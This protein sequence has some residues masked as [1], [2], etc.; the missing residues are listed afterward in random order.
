MRLYG[1]KN[2]RRLVDK[3]T[4]KK[5][6][7]R[8]AILWTIEEEVC[9]VKIQGSN[10]LVVAHFPRNQREAPLWLRKG[11]AVRIVHKDGIRG[12]IEIVGEGRSIPAPVAG[13][14]FPSIGG[15]SD[16]ILSGLVVTSTVPAS[17]NVEISA[18]SYRIGGV[19]YYME[20]V[21]GGYIVMD[22]PAPMIM[23]D[24]P[25]V[26]NGQV[27]Y[28]LGA[29][30]GAGFFRYDIIVIGTD[31]DLDLIVG[32]EVASDPVMPS[33]PS[34]HILVNFILRIGGDTDV[35]MRRIGFLY[36]ASYP[37]FLDMPEGLELSWS[38]IIDNPTI[39]FTVVVKDQYSFSTSSAGGWIMT[40][41]KIFGSG[42]IWSSRSGW[43]S[44]EVAQNLVS[45]TDYTF[46]Y[47]RDQTA[48]PE[49]SPHFQVKLT[50]GRSPLYG[51]AS[52]ILL[53]DAGQPI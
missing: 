14:A 44:D 42:E 31:G 2:I 11:N 22:D 49:Y 50:G 32:D 28:D 51:F 6:E 39:N 25:F 47:R 45:L 4:S 26:L 35:P 21:A 27:N 36:E 13:G 20:E 52:I 37:A 8:N 9:R 33:I 43:D 19:I 15:L 34:N 30:P 23:G 48:S 1:K 3:R 17:N 38:F 7:M 16:G 41:T 24:L 40:L 5:Q 10:E 12:Y 46:I 18:G 53:D 29:A